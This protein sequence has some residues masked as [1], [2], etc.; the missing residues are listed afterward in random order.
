MTDRELNAFF[1]GVFAGILLAGVAVILTR[2][3]IL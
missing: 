1:C 3:L 2:W